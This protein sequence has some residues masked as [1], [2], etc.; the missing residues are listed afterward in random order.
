MW[1]ELHVFYELFYIYVLSISCEIFI[2]ICNYYVIEQYG[3]GMA[4]AYN[5]AM[6]ISSNTT[7]I[8]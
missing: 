5:V 8:P 3:F 4:F 7:G 1:N 6:A 2:I